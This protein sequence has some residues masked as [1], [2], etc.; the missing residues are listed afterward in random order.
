MSL[1]MDPIFTPLRYSLTKTVATKL[2]T[3][4]AVHVMVPVMGLMVMGP[5]AAA[6]GNVNPGQGLF[7]LF[8]GNDR[9]QCKESPSG[10]KGRGLYCQGVFTGKKMAA[11]TK[12]KGVEL[13]KLSMAV[14]SV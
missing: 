5:E 13:L 14:T 1:R 11:G 12:K 6:G 7:Q 3:V 4:L 8:R 9:S 10:S 2:P